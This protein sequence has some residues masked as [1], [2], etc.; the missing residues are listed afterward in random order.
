[1]IFRSSEL[2]WVQNTQKIYLNDFMTT[3][4]DYHLHDSLKVVKILFLWR[5]F[6]QVNLFYF[7]LIYW[8]TCRIPYGNENLS[9]DEY[10]WGISCCPLHDLFTLIFYPWWVIT[11]KLGRDLTF[12]Q[13]HLNT[14]NSSVISR[15][16]VQYVT[17]LFDIV[18]SLSK[19]T[20]EHNIWIY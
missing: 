7:G 6:L 1:M 14:A 17:H 16:L 15:I 11:D 3:W 5:R 18:R 12:F 19:I 20:L 8:F 10:L 2:I 9:S 13:I 4:I